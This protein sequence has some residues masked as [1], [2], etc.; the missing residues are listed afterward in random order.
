ML[1]SDAVCRTCSCK[2]MTIAEYQGCSKTSQAIWRNCGIRALVR[3]WHSHLKGLPCQNCSYDKHTEFA[4][5]KAI[6]K[7]PLTATL[8]EVNS[9]SNLL[10]LCP[11]CHW[12]LD[13]GLLVV[14]EIPLRRMVGTQGIAPRS[15]GLEHRTLSI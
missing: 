6:S 5:V 8:Q 3:S 11:N 10:M 9:E 14:E 7:F 13:N 12:E 2:T 15:R 4:H 1:K